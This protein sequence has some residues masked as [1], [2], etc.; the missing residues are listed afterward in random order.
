[1]KTKKYLKIFLY[2]FIGTFVFVACQKENKTVH[3]GV[4]G[5]YIGNFTVSNTLKSATIANGNRMDTAVVK[6]I[7]NGQINVHCFGDDMDS[8]FILN[9]Y[10]NGDSLMVCLDGQ[11]FDNEYG[12]MMGDGS[13]MGSGGMMG[14]NSTEWGQHMNGEHKVG[15]NHFGGFDMQNGTFSYSF[16][17][18]D[19][20]ST[21]YRKFQG[22]RK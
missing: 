17:M 2:A 18:M 3:Q 11:D 9:T 15:D 16:K 1:M 10:Q 7:S 20:T 13:M 6:L 5:T 22:T 4:E 19:G 14:N 12:H 8:T 21:N